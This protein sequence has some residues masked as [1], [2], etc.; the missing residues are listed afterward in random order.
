MIKINL[1]NKF[2]TLYGLSHNRHWRFRI[3]DDDT[4]LEELTVHNYDIRLKEK[5]I[6]CSIKDVILV[7]LQEN[8]L[9]SL[10]AYIKAIKIVTNILI[11][12][13]RTSYFY[14]C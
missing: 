6:V 2:I 14:C 5:R 1:E 12:S 8:N 10:N 7:D 4:K 3:V 13:K 9:Y 11:Y